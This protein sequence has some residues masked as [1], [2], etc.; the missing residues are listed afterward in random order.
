MR[1]G[2]V[3]NLDAELELALPSYNPKLSVLSQLAQYGGGSRALLGP[4]DIELGPETRATASLIGRAWCPTRRA[5]AAFAA[6]GIEPEPHPSLAVLRRVNHRRFAHELGGGLPEQHYV[7]ERGAVEALLARPG[8][9]MLKRP[10]TLAGRGQLR[11]FRELSVKEW[12]WVDASL[13][14]DGLIVEPLVLPT[15][16]LSQHGFVWPSGAY[17]LGRACVQEVTPRGVFRGIR[18]A[19]SELSADEA[20]ALRDTSER[21][22]LALTNAGYFG[23]FG[24]DAY[25]YERDGESGFCALG[26]INARYTMGFAVGFPRPA[27]E[28]SLA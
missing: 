18:L 9:W 7:D 22:A 14:H 6:A 24:V 3:F 13:A 19:A 27:H 15:L 8:Q 4:E 21:V 2:W 5:L 26:E 11:A 17:E 25:R 12:T 28:L 20:R 23:P 10:L 1:F 16:E